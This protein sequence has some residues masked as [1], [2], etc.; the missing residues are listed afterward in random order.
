LRRPKLKRSG[1][2]SRCFIGGPW[3]IIAR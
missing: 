2:T 3:L 1:L